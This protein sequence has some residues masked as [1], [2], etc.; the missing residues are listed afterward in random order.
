MTR[1]IR[2]ALFLGA[3]LSAFASA[4]SAQEA[5]TRADAVVVT[6]V[7]AG[8]ERS[9]LESTVPIDV[10]QGA[11]IARVSAGGDLNAA[12][13][14]LAPSFNFQRQST[15]GPADIVRAAQLR[16]MSP[17]QTLVLV[18]G[19]RRN[20][21]SVVNLEAKLGRGTTPVD[22]ASI[23]VNA[24][25]RIE[26][27]RDGAGAQ[28]G[29]DAIAGVINVILDARPEGGEASVSYGAHITDFEPTGQ[30]ITDGRTLQLAGSY[31]V[32]LGDGGFLRFGAE[33]QNREETN[34]A[35]FD[36]IA[37]FEEQTPD[38][39]RFRGQRN[40]RP[41]DPEL[42]N[43][44]LWVNGELPLADYTVY[45]F[46]TV[47]QREGEGAAFFRYPDDFRNIKTIYPN[48]YRPVTTGKN[49]DIA[50][51]TGLKGVIG[52]WDWDASLN[53]GVNDYTFGVKNSLNPSLGA[54]SP[55]SFRL[56]DFSTSLLA[57][58]IDLN[59]PVNLGFGSDAAL[60]LGVEARAETFESKPGDPD[61]WRAGG[62]V[63]RP[64]GA[65]A[66]P[67]L[68][69]ED[70]ADVDRSVL[71]AYG[72]LSVDLSEQVSVVAAGRLESYEDFGEALS[73]KLSARWAPLDGLS[74]RGSVSNSFRAPSLSQS[75]Y[76]FAVTSFGDGGRLT[77]INTLAPS[78]PIARALGASDL[79]AE[80]SFNLSAGFTLQL[81]SLLTLTVDAFQIQLDDRITLS[82]RISGAP[83]SALLNQR[84]GAAA[85]GITAVN[86]FTNAI[87][88]ETNGVDVVASHTSDLFGGSL[89]ASL[90]YNYAKTTIEGVDPTPQALRALGVGQVLI[91]PEER[92]TVVSASPR[93]KLIG[94]LSW[95]GERLSLVARA[96]HYGSAVRVFNFGGGFEPDQKFD[97]RTQV[98]L[99][100]ELQLTDRLALAIGGQ[101]VLDEYPELSNDLLNY[102]GSLPYDFVSPIGFNGAYYYSRLKVTF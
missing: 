24:I 14:V 79:D 40:F 75:A 35:G 84:F 27:L 32:A 77:T 47:N 41:G 61:S 30:D 102:F 87:D 11:E 45:G 4:A 97:A 37:F 95:T 46:A 20:P 12:L 90:A 48:G 29:S 44:N 28:Y 92:N 86:F 66:G 42:Q 8:G 78:N 67:G 65:Q 2:S 56:A 53:V 80:E 15:S 43:L 76:Q 64:V 31:G 96:T 9:V 85:A 70:A 22:F 25:G 39:L 101:N 89:F 21:T 26:V 60:A 10:L 68:R 6:G 93:S 55:R 100:A 57:I 59:R 51:T 58:N 99:E 82:E 52:G 54:F 63:G 5:V 81:S 1:T 94:T 7:R 69:P 49:Q 88:T 73:G 83:V 13:N 36:Q 23:P 3:A 38:N 71:A 72:E 16:G 17:D 18:N 19:K 34:R 33:Y 62:S 50:V 91:G 74:F 98:D